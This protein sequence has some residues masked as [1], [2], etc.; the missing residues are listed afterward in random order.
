MKE[1]TYEEVLKIREII[2]RNI[3]LVTDMEKLSFGQDRI[4][5]NIIEEIIR[6]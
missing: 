6:I 2:A 3:W 1:V 5:K 4:L